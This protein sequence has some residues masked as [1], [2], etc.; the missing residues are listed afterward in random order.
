M[1][2]FVCHY[3]RTLIIITF[4]TGFLIM[5]LCTFGNFRGIPEM[6]LSLILTIS[7]LV[8]LF[9]TIFTLIVLLRGC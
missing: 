2:D 5:R 9:L 6:I 8:S 4:I 3:D 1:I 7:A